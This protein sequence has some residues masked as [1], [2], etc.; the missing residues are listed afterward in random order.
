M[1]ARRLASRIA[2]GIAAA[3][4]VAVVAFLVWASQAYHADGVFDQVESVSQGASVQDGPRIAVSQDD[5]T[6]AVAADGATTGIILYPGAKVD[7]DAY[8]PL[9]YD[10]AARGYCCVIAKMPLDLAMFDID[11]ASDIAAAHPEIDSW[12]IG[13]HSLGGAMAAQYASSHPEDLRGVVLLASY[14]ATDIS[15]T[16]LSA[17]TIY[18]TQDGVLDRDRL[19]KNAANLPTDSQTAII[20]GGNHAGFGSYGVQSGD[21]DASIAPE[22]QQQRTADAIADFIETRG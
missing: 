22:D 13:G 17:L 6:I 1:N 20:D 15:D 14:S 2:L 21:G 12:W 5:R 11:A 7:A 4:A 18:G 19:E 10:I 8:T 16:D 9:A 3:L